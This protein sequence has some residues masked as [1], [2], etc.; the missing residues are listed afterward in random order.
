MK[1]IKVGYLRIKIMSYAFS[2]LCQFFE[3]TLFNLATY[4]FF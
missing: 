4:I 2:V 1:Q 3:L